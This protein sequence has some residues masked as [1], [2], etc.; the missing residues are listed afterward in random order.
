MRAIECG[1]C[2][3]PELS[4]SDGYFVC[5]YCRSKFVVERPSSAPKETTIEMQ[6]DVEVLLKKCVDDP[7]NRR[8][9]ASLVLDI[10]PTNPEA[11]KYLR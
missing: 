2:G 4:E 5:I 1:R 11:S 8:R 9:Y 10:D 7:L 6:S 3:S